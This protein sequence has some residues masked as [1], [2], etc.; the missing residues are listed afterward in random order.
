MEGTFKR[1]EVLADESIRVAM[2]L[3]YCIVSLVQI[4]YCISIN[5]ISRHT[6]EKSWIFNRNTSR[7]RLGVF[8]LVRAVK[9]YDALASFQI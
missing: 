6:A 2:F 7:P 8:F 5:D 4:C 3:L 9:L 1:S